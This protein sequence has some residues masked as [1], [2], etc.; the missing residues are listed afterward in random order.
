MVACKI[1]CL[2]IQIRVNGEGDAC[3]HDRWWSQWSFLFYMWAKN[4]KNKCHSLFGVTE[5]TL[6]LEPRFVYCSYVQS[7][8]NSIRTS[9]CNTILTRSGSQRDSH[10][11]Y[12]CSEHVPLTTKS[13]VTMGHPIRSREQINGSKVL[14]SS[15]AI[16][17]ST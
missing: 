2:F 8:K 5:E 17:G 10:M 15:P 7:E 6:P 1:D 12:I 3:S 16:T 11:P 9:V 13:S 14:G 4:R